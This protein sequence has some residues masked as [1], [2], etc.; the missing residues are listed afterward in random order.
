MLAAVVLASLGTSRQKGR[1]ARRISDIS[2]IKLALELY[3]DANST[4]PTD[5]YAAGVLAPS[6]ISSVPTDPSSNANYPYSVL[7]GAAPSGSGLCGSYHLGASLETQQTALSSDIDATAGGTYGTG[8]Q[9]GATCG[10]AADFN[11]LDTGSCANP[12][13]VGTYCYDVRP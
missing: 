12:Q 3:Y 1:D 2:Q 4:F 7:V 10:G 6:Y 11:G 8:V 9:D 13:V 5:I